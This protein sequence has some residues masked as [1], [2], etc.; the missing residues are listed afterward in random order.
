MSAPTLA[1]SAAKPVQIVLP[2]GCSTI[3]TATQQIVVCRPIEESPIEKILPALPA[4]VVSVIAL[5]FSAKS[6]SYSRRKDSRARHQSIIDDY[7]L[8]KIVSP[9]SI[10]PLLKRT[11]ELAA[12]LP[13]G[14]ATA[15][16]VQSYWTEQVTKSE[17]LSI[18][19]QSLKLIDEALSDDVLL[20]LLRLDDVL[21]DYCGTLQSSLADGSIEKPDRKQAVS[22]IHE[23]SMAIFNAIKQHQVAVGNELITPFDWKKPSTWPLLRPSARR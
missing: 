21:S 12:S 9:V 16:I 19:F 14:T 10:E 11:T 6:Y 7:W 22:D 5:V 15:A 13:S 4:L 20:K 18:G 1:S 17:E 8:R 23:A 3:N 2:N